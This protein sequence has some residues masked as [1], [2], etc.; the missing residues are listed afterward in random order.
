MKTSLNKKNE[1]IFFLETYESIFEEEVQYYYRIIYNKLEITAW[2]DAPPG[3]DKNRVKSKTDVNPFK[4]LI[5]LKLGVKSHLKKHLTPL[6]KESFEYNRLFIGLPSYSKSP[7]YSKGEFNIIIQEM[8]NE[9]ALINKK[10]QQ[11]KTP[12]IDYLDEIGL[13]PKPTGYNNNSWT[14]TCPNAK[15]SHF[16][17]VSTLN[18]DWGCGYCRRNGNQDE[19]DKW[20]NE[21]KDKKNAT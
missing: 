13:Y 7:L 5:L 21:I 17:C 14:A 8:R 15:G 1:F 10:A 6:L 9:L 2:I 3:L 18:D 4:I 19:L 16:I 11:A 20:I 12:F